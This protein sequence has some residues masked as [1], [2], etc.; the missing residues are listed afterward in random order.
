MDLGTGLF[1]T[2]Q[3]EG[4][5]C[6]LGRGSCANRTEYVQEGGKEQLGPC[7]VKGELFLLPSRAPHSGHQAEGTFLEQKGS[8]PQQVMLGSP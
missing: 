2:D 6:F 1:F 4:N 3:C 7:G 5:T 8:S